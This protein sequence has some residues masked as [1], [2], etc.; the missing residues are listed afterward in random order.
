MRLAALSCSLALFSL[1]ATPSDLLMQDGWL[2]S[3]SSF[4][5]SVSFS[6]SKVSLSLE[7]ETPVGGKAGEA[8][9]G[10]TTLT[11]RM[12]GW[13]DGEAEWIGRI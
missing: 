5:L 1:F 8:R 7:S 10:K 12:D 2:K 6:L 4:W 9:Q 13:M 11:T 3:V